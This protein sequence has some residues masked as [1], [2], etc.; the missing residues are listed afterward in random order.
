MIGLFSLES[1]WN[2]HIPSTTAIKT[3]NEKERRER[4]RWRERGRANNNC[5]GQRAY[6]DISVSNIVAAK[7]PKEGDYVQ[8]KTDGR[9]WR[10]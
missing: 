1:C 9:G 6:R 3:E 2:A 7:V 4:K 8:R 5:S 10:F